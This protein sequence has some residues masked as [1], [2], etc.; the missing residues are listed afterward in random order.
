MGVPGL[1]VGV[2]LGQREAGCPHSPLGWLDAGT[3]AWPQTPA[4]GRH[5]AGFQGFDANTVHTRK[6][7]SC[8]VLV[9]PGHR[10]QYSGIWGGALAHRTGP[11]KHRF[12]AQVR[13]C[14]AQE[15]LLDQCLGCSK[16]SAQDCSWFGAQG[17]ALDHCSGKLLHQCSEVA[18]GSILRDAPSFVLKRYSIVSAQGCSGGTLAPVLKFLLKVL[19]VR[20]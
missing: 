20:A 6:P 18:P 5:W 19:R 15:L 2:C 4:R 12:L 13:C 8:H 3:P 7:E 14:S 10:K 11:T 1:Q 9:R 17:G 16:I